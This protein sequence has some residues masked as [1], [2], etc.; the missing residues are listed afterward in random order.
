MRCIRNQTDFRTR[1]TPI[2]LHDIGTSHPDFSNLASRKSLAVLDD[3]DVID[4]AWQSA[5][6][7]KEFKGVGRQDSENPDV[8]VGRWV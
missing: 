3:Q 5:N 2:L 6:P 4:G 8:L 1:V 7:Q